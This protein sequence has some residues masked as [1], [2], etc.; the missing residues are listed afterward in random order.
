VDGGGDGVKI[1]I[2]NVDYPG[3]LESLYGLHPGLDAAPYDEQ[4][5]ARNESFFG[6]ADFY[7]SNLR[8]LGHEAWDIHANNE[9]MQ[10]AWAREHG[11]AVRTGSGYRMQVRLRRG[12][13]PWVSRVADRRWMY[14]VLAAQI[15]HYRPDV[16]LNQVLDGISGTFLAGMKDA[17][18]LLVGQIASPLPD[19]SL[20][21]YDLIISSLPNFVERFRRDGIPSEL[22]R[23]AFEPRVLDALSPEARTIPISFVGSISRHHAARIDLMEGLC[24]RFAIELWGQGAERLPEGSPIRAHHHGTAWGLEMYGI[25]NRSRIALNHHISIAEGY[26]NNMRL[27]EATGVGALLL[28]D[29][30]ENLGEMFEPGREVVA[31]RTHEE[32]AEMV[33]YYLDHEEERAAIARAGQERTLRDHTYRVRMEELAETLDRRLRARPAR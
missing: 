16:V 25:L 29:W 31:Y 3:F 21:M 28:T 17:M 13:V 2:L 26:A 32:C 4:M 20:A 33:R 18:K 27:F 19:E 14:D 9:V 22:S 24:A 12:I 6:V 7:S 23:F 30:K 11:V 5:R 1:L 15:R 8:A 10:R